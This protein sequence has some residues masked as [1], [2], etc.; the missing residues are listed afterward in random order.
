MARGMGPA[1]RFNRPR[2]SKESHRIAAPDRFLRRTLGPIYGLGTRHGGH[3]F[4][5]PLPPYAKACGRRKRQR[6]TPV[7]EKSRGQTAKGTCNPV[8]GE[9][10]HEKG[11]RWS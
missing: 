8:K 1:C 9:E 6:S 11:L 4:H 10:D 3:S 5:A 2:S 7:P